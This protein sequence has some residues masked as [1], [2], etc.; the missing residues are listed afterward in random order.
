MD[1]MA[2]LKDR[3]RSDLTAAMK[4]RDKVTVRTL[5][6]ALTSVTKEEVAGTTARELS[7]D[8]V[9]TVL[10]REAK[11]RREA[12]DAFAAAG[13][14]EQAEAERAEGAVLDTYLPAQ[15]GDAELGELVTA[16]IEETGA[17]TLRDMGQVM[18]VL[19]PRVAGRAEGG[20]VAA[21]VRRRLQ[22]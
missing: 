5:R 6:M 1:A 16:A 20:R 18:K 3:L 2:A 12:A 11:R 13:R 14:D 9:L 21:E 19:T 8:E 15:L 7:D 22:G 10:T 17:S 4:A